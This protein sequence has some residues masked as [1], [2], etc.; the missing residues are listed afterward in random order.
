[1]KPWLA[2][3]TLDVQ[4]LS[5]LN[6]LMDEGVDMHFINLA[7]A[8]GIPIIALENS[9]EQLRIFAD[10]DEKMSQIF[11]KATIL[12]LGKIREVMGE[13]Q[14]AWQSGNVVKF[15][16][17]FFDT[18]KEWPELLPLVDTIIYQRNDKMFERIIPVVQQPGVTFVV[19]GSGHVIGPRGLPA[20]FEKAG[21][22]VK[23]F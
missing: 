18:F 2:A 5:A 22:T 12:E 16:E 1:M 11:L 8:K 20:L 23:K 13:L 4:V 17:L 9:V 15:E 7:E 21:Y 10:M 3:V 6:Y 19:I 14:D